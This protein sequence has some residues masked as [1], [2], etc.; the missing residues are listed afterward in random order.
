MKPVSTALLLV[1]AVFSLESQA[2]T[3]AT[4][5]R[6][7]WSLYRTD[8]ST[9]LSSHASETDCVNAAKALNVTRTACSGQE[10]TSYKKCDGKASC[11]NYVAA[12]TPEACQ[13]AAT[14]ACANDRLTV[15]KSKVITATFQ[16][17]P[18]KSKSGD[19]F[20]AD[21]ANRAAEFNQCK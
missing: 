5:T 1:A 6:G 4:V 14:K 2:A 18:L 9:R 17:K 20:C 7:Q 8:S 3:T 12:A 11:V 21:Y 15:T 10:A 13:E 19:D 16:D